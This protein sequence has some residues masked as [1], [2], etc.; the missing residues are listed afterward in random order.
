VKCVRLPDGR[1]GATLRIG[2]AMGQVVDAA[3]L[4]DIELAARFEA[5]MA[6]IRTA[7]LRASG[8]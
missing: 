6:A 1:W 2:L 3:S 7:L 4:D 5:D 8:V